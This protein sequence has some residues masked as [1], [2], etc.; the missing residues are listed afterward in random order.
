MPGGTTGQIIMF[1]MIDGNSFP[2]RLAI[3]GQFDLLVDAGGSVFAEKNHTINLRIEVLD[4]FVIFE[5]SFIPFLQWPGY[6][7][8]GAQVSV[9]SLG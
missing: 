8:W 4:L 6:D 3:A 5:R 9:A 7:G 1:A 2:A